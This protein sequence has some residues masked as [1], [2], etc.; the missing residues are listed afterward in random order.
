M[1]QYSHLVRS[2][3]AVLLSEKMEDELEGRIDRV[4]LFTDYKANWNAK[5][6]SPFLAK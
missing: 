5:G 2:E 4:M 6:I 3:Q 1:S